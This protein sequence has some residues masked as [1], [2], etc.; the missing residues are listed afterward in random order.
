MLRSATV[1]A[2]V[3]AAGSALAAGAVGRWTGRY[4]VERESADTPPAYR[5]REVEALTEIYK[6]RVFL[7][8][9]K[10]GTFVMRCEGLAVVRRARSFGRWR[11]SRGSST[12]SA[13]Q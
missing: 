6:G 1:F 5:P 9:R 8:I 4:R 7:E 13:D 3:L 2:L 10:D 12:K 11:R